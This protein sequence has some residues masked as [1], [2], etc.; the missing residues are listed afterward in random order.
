MYRPRDHTKGLALT[1][2]GAFLIAS[3]AVALVVIGLLFQLGDGAPEAMHLMAVS[4]AIIPI[5]AMWPWVT[6]KYQIFE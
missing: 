6:G 1:F 2:Y 4:F 3:Y 5:F